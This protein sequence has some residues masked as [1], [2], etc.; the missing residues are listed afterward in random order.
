MHL[1]LVCN[2]SQKPEWKQ[3]IDCVGNQCP[4]IAGLK[5]VLMPP[6]FVGAAKLEIHKTMRRLPFHNLAGP[7]QRK[8]VNA[9]TVVDKSPFLDGLRLGLANLKVQPRRNQFLKVLGPRKE[10]K[11]LRQRA[12]HLLRESQSIGFMPHHVR[13]SSIGTQWTRPG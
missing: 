5:A 13:L 3:K 10:A 7:A 12:G 1:D 4:S 8:A 6:Q 9:Q 11:D 2:L